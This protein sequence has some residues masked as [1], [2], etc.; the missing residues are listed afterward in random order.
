M[1]KYG[2]IFERTIKDFNE[3]RTRNGYVE[4]VIY[5]RQCREVCV[6]LV[7]SDLIEQVKRLKW[8][9]DGRGYVHSKTGGSY[10]KLHQLVLPKRD[11]FVI[12]HINRDKLDNRRV[13]LRYLLPYR[14]CH[15][16]VRKGWHF[17]KNEKKWVAY[18]TIKKKRVHLGY[19]RNEQEAREARKKAEVEFGVNF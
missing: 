9:L 6:A 15:N 18:I 17:A 10:R 13:N 14:N 2:E 1:D 5:D 7:D 11:G 4:I 8:G 16:R 3:I 19:F 12:D